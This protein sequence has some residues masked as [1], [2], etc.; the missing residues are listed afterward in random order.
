MGG[1]IGDAFVTPAFQG[2]TLLTIIF[3]M[4]MQDPMLGLAAVALYPVQGYVIPKLQR[5][6]NQ[7]GKRRVRTI[8]QV[9]DRVHESAAGIVD[10]QA[11]DNGQAA[12]DQLSPICWARFTTSASRSIKR[13]FF[14]KFLNNFLGQLTPFFFFSIGGYLVIRGQLS[15]GALVAVLA[16]YKDLASPWKEL[17]DFY[18]IIPGFA[19]SNTSRSSSNS[20]PPGM[21]DARLLLEEPETVAPLDRRARRSPTCRSPRTTA[22]GSSTASALRVPLDRARR[23]HRPRRQRQERARPA[24]RAADPADQRP[25]HDRRHRHRE[26]CRPRSSA[27]GSAMSAR[28][29]T[30]SPAPCATICCSACATDPVRPAEYEPAIAKRRARPTLRGATIRQYRLRHPRRLDRL[31]SAGVADR[32]GAVAARRRGA[33]PSRLRRGRLSLW[34]CAGGSIPRPSPRRPSRLLEARKALARRLAEDGITNLVETYDAERFN[35]NASVAENLLFGTPIGP[36]F[37]FDALADNT[38]VLQVLTKVGLTDDLVEA[39]RQVAETMIEMFAD[40]PPDHEFFEQFSFISANDLPEFAAIL[41]RVGKGDTAA[42]AKDDRAKLLSLP[43]KLIP[44]RHRLDVLDEPMQQ[45]AARGAQGISRRSSGRGAARRS[46][47]ST[48]S[49]TTPPPRCRTTS[50]SARSPMARRMRRCG[51]RGA[52]RGDRRAVAAPDRH[53][54]RARL[55]CRHRRTRACRLAQRQKA[56]IARAVLKRPDLLILNEATSALDGQAQAKVIKGLKEEFAGRGLI[57]V[58][59]RASLARNFDRVLVMSGGK[60]ARAGQRFGARQ[61]NG[62][63]MSMLI[64]AE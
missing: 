12:A 45:P 22:A 58:L 20:S 57:W 23:G 15:F 7:L 31:R 14:V 8:R 30:C 63:L 64:A 55:Q 44:A 38:Y 34:G 46:S 60:L 18:Q 41:G 25:D 2:G 36:A 26:P 52:R 35:L 50:C 27:G 39:G 59:H 28:R 33:G 16:A 5:K 40:L 43:F 62:S 54:C 42:L 17:L 11:N 32:E 19:R 6:V 51:S 49:A 1:F 37:D 56:A 61:G 29:P 48:P 47:S 10:I 24:A 4:F 21:I 3:F 13:K 53:R 9:A